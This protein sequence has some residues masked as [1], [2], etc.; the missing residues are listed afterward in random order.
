MDYGI[1]INYLC[2]INFHPV[3]P[4]EVRQQ[5]TDAMMQGDQA[6]RKARDANEVNAE[7]TT[8]STSLVSLAS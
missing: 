8:F 7:D 2:L 3:K 1:R 6:H 5:L 4:M